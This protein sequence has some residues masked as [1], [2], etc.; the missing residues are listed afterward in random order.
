MTVR[1]HKESEKIRIMRGVR[2]GDTISPKLFT[3]TLP[4]LFGRLTLGNKG[5][6]IDG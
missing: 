1:L 3:A 6:K 2:Q 4:N 5:V